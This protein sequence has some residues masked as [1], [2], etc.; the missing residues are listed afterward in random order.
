MNGVEIEKRRRWC[1]LKEEGGHICYNSGD[2]KDKKTL[3]EVLHTVPLIHCKA[4]NGNGDYSASK[5]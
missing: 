1:N 5:I 4:I 3:K 2:K